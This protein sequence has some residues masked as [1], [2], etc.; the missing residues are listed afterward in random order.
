MKSTLIFSLI[1]AATLTACD[2]NGNADKTE[3]ATEMEATISGKASE[4]SDSMSTKEKEISQSIEESVSE[5]AEIVKE[6]MESIHEN[7]ESNTME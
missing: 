7:E 2:D 5:D 4:L 1:M 6:N 3:T